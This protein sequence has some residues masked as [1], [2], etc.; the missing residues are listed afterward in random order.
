MNNKTQIMKSDLN[1]L[2]LLEQDDNFK[3]RLD[4]AIEVAK[5]IGAYDSII[6]YYTYQPYLSELND[7]DYY[8]LSCYER[9]QNKE[10]FIIINK[11]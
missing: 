4:N 6:V 2:M 10:Y 7:I 9:F 8:A 5:M 3:I 11:K 1:T